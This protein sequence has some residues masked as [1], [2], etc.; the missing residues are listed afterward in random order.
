MISARAFSNG[1]LYDCGDTSV[2]ARSESVSVSV[3]NLGS[4]KDR[5]NDRFVCLLLECLCRV[6]MPDSGEVGSN[7]LTFVVLVVYMV[8]LSF[9]G[10]MT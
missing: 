1:V 6:E 5:A 4:D 8:L 3:S 10:W 7:E 2:V 9:A